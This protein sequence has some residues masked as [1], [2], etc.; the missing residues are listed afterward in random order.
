MSIEKTREL[1]QR[2]KEEQRVLRIVYHRPDAP[3]PSERDIDVYEFSG[4]YFAGFCHRSAQV[5]AFRVDRIVQIH[6]LEERF[7]PHPGVKAKIQRDRQY[8]YLATLTEFPFPP[9]S[10][11]GSETVKSEYG[12]CPVG[13]QGSEGKGRA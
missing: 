10:N 2:A 9:R 7:H 3:D 6:L 11:L 4:F 5:R 12:A 8:A 13:E 1:L